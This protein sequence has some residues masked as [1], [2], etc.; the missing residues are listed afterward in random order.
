MI[1]LITD[2]YNAEGNED[3]MKHIHKYNRHGAGSRE[4]I[5]AEKTAW[6]RSYRTKCECGDEGHEEEV[7]TSILSF[8]SFWPERRYS[9][10]DPIQT[11]IKALR[12]EGKTTNEI[13]VL[14]GGM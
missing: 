9:E 10:R 7:V 8:T 11:Q 12:G 2:G 14:L 3:L 6:V 4:Y 13:N 5:N 1:R